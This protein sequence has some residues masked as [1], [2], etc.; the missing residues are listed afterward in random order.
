MISLIT[1]D[2][3]RNRASFFK[4][5]VLQTIVFFLILF[6][7]PK[8][9]FP[10]V[11]EFV[12]DDK[13]LRQGFS[14][15]ILL[16]LLIPHY[17]S[18]AAVT[19]Q[20]LHDIGDSAMFLLLTMIPIANLKLAWRL[21]IAP[22]QKGPN[23][24]GPF[25]ETGYASYDEEAMRRATG[26]AR[27]GGAAEVTWREGLDEALTTAED[28]ISPEPRPSGY[29]PPDRSTPSRPSSPAARQAGPRPPGLPAKRTFGRKIS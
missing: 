24:F 16:L 17:F 19:A 2:G 20:R 9:V 6:L 22:S 18:V 26:P 5:M 8:F 13:D 14:G 15:L 12:G 21:L 27:G 1:F 23:C 3:R 11:D 29:P 25:P 28:T 10:V 4:M 7:A